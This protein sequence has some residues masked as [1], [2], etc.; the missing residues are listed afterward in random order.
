MD[1]PRQGLGGG[2]SLQKR[3][4]LRFPL[5]TKTQIQGESLQKLTFCSIS[6]RWTDPFL[7]SG[8]VG[9]DTSGR[10]QT[11]GLYFASRI[12]PEGIGLKEISPEELELHVALR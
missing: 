8:V 9:Q 12:S 3:S 11:H 1:V 2:K 7:H 5:L 6:F 10:P 4:W